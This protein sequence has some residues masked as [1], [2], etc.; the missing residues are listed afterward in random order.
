MD[1]TQIVGF[2]AVDLERRLQLVENVIEV[3]GFYIVGGGKSVSVHRVT[4]PDHRETLPVDRTDQPWQ[5]LLHLIDT[6]PG[7]QYNLARL[8][9]QIGRA[10]CRERAQNSGD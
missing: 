3:S 1:A 5:I 6:E 8:M 10:S 2:R 7:D 4:A 9:G